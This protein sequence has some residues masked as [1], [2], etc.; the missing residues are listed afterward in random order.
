MGAFPLP[1][2]TGLTVATVLVVVA[3]VARVVGAVVVAVA[4]IA[5]SVFSAA[6]VA[7][8]GEERLH[9]FCPLLTISFQLLRPSVWL[10]FSG[11]TV[12]F[13]VDG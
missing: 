8:V 13:E 1:S 7:A 11:P 10:I 6:S 12:S 2:C 9:L 4:S 5:A 3:P